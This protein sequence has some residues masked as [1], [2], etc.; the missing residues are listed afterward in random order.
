MNLFNEE[1]VIE[2][3]C[4]E[5]VIGVGC[6]DII[7][8]YQ[9]LIN[10]HTYYVARDDRFIARASDAEIDKNNCCN[11]LVFGI[12]KKVLG[13]WVTLPNKERKPAIIEDHNVTDL[14]SYCSLIHEYKEIINRYSNYGLYDL[15]YD[16]TK[17][18][19]IT[20]GKAPTKEITFIQNINYRMYFYKDT[21]RIIARAGNGIKNIQN[22]VFY[23]E[24]D[25]IAFAKESDEFC[26]DY[27]L[28]FK[29]YIKSGLINEH[30]TKFCARK[31]S[32]TNGNYYEQQKCETLSQVDKLELLR[33][34]KKLMQEQLKKSMQLYG[35]R[36]GHELCDQL[37]TSV[38]FDSS[39]IKKG[40]KS[41]SEVKLNSLLLTL[42]GA[43]KELARIKPIS[44]D[45]VF[46][47]GFNNSL[48]KK[49][50]EINVPISE[51][52]I[53]EDFEQKPENSINHQ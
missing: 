33:Q 30:Y 34:I 5:N 13:Y 14:T 4:E 46:A 22:V 7:N 32:E 39:M 29:D 41:G 43:I 53:K 12:E 28:D 3:E 21:G 9:L 20:G 26:R 27:N 16:I 8:C 31:K 52:I 38:Q 17:G 50:E 1:K 44:D 40:G 23:N 48:I 6:I 18:K 42:E 24:E 10:N 2:M 11:G 15:V 35:N 47:D 51:A 49:I 25:F 37:N 19:S 45:V 36:V